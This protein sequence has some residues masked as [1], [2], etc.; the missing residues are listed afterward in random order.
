MATLY[1]TLEHVHQ[2][3]QPYFTSGG[4]AVYT[5]YTEDVLGRV[6]EADL[7]DGVHSYD[8]VNETVTNPDSF[9]TTTVR[10][11]PG[12]IT[13]VTDALSHASSY[14]YDAFGNPTKY[15]DAVGNITTYAYDVLGRRS[16]MS[17]PDRGSWSWSYDSL[18]EVISQTD[19]KGQATS[20]SYDLLGRTTRRVEP[21]LTSS[22]TYDTATYS[23]G[24]LASETTGSG[25]SKTYTYDS[26]SRET[27][28]A[29]NITGWQGSFNTGYDSYGRVSWIAYPG[30]GVGFVYNSYGYTSS[31]SYGPIGTIYTVNTVD[32]ELHQTSASYGPVPGNNA[33]TQYYSTATG[34]LISACYEGPSTAGATTPGTYY[35]CLSYTYDHNL[36]VLTR[37]DSGTSETETYDQLDRILTSA[38]SLNGTAGPSKSFAYDAGGNLTSKNDV[39]AY[40]YPTAGA[41]RPHA[42]SSIAPSGSGTVSTSFTYDA[43]GNMLTGNGRTIT[44]TSFNMPASITEGSKTVSFT[45]DP[46]HN[47]ITQATPEG[48]LY[49]FRGA[50]ELAELTATSTK[51]DWRNY[52]S[53]SGRMIGMYWD[54]YTVS[55]STVTLASSTIRYYLPDALGSEVRLLDQNAMPAETDGY[56]AWG[57][58]RYPSG[59]DDAANAIASQ[60]TRGFTGEEHLPDT[61]SLVHLNGRMAKIAADLDALAAELAGLAGLSLNELKDHWRELYQTEP[62]KRISRQLL[63]YAIGYRI[64][65]RLLGGLKPER[66][67]LLDRDGAKKPRVAVKPGTRLVRQWHG[68]MHE[69]EVGDDGIVYRGEFHRSLSQVA[70]LITGPIGR[71]LPSSA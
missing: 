5:S 52:L 22:W 55:G 18:G 33:L 59:A 65:E 51:Q 6:T 13:K 23:K 14:V 58:R 34:Q 39:G 1:D 42:V 53:F 54:H 66:V 67:K 38:V 21:D 56:D 41:A 7:P 37:G 57:K 11:G 8:G 16:T 24:K 32:A 12:Q 15:T 68:V 29:L 20:W 49:Y 50:G 69:V 64:Q 44:W 17:D 30:R 61:P 62:P 3:S 4:T 26:L 35:A 9:A 71:V 31:E 60:T 46:E 45:Y 48:T 10:N 63:C 19:A 28:T 40:T 47:R 70:Y 2:V 36:N 27:Q 25:Y 43:N